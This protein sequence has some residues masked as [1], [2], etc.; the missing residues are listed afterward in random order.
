MG[1]AVAHAVEGKG[2][3]ACAGKVACPKVK[4]H[5]ASQ[6][7]ADVCAECGIKLLSEG[8]GL[9]PHDAAGPLDIGAKG[10]CAY[11][12]VGRHGQFGIG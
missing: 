11:K 3:I 8:V 2:G 12:V 5:I 10:K 1:K 7:G 4:L 9:V 6:R